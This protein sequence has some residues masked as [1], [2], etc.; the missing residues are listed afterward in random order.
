MPQYQTLAQTQARQRAQDLALVQTMME[1]AQR[2]WTE[3]QADARALIARLET[4]CAVEKE[5]Q[6]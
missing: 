2:Q 3:A 1:E 5:V 6:P 4:E